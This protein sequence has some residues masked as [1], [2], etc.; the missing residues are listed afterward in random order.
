[1]EQTANWMK[2]K[3]KLK[4]LR[5]TSLTT[6]CRAFEAISVEKFWE[7]AARQQGPREGFKK[8]KKWQDQLCGLWPRGV[9]GCRL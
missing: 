1:M 9:W 3:I 4:V 2:L 7:R 6:E 8:A 5:N